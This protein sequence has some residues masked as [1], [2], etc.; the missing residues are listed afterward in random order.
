MKK[1]DLSFED[2]DDEKARELLPEEYEPLPYVSISS[3]IP[4]KLIKVRGFTTEADAIRRLK[5]INSVYPSNKYQIVPY[6]IEP[7]IHEFAIVIP[8]SAKAYLNKDEVIAD[9]DPPL[10]SRVSYSPVLY[11][12]LGSKKYENSFF[13]TG[14]LLISTFKRCQSKEVKDRQ[15]KYENQNR[16]IIVDGKYSI[17][18]VIGF[19]SPSLLLCTSL[20]QENTQTCGDT[21][22]FKINNADQFFDML[23]RALIS[24]GLSVCEVVKGPCVYNNKKI[25]LNASGTGFIGAFLKDSEQGCLNFLPSFQFI[26][27]QAENHILMNKPTCFASES[28]YRFVW[29]LTQPPR[30]ETVSE[31]VAV[32]GDGS[33]IVKVPELIPFCERL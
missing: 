21:Y 11:R 23:T 6:S 7:V 25:V 3:P 32:N 8:E 28:E 29:K 31:D 19:E 12:F 22:G 1:S 26:R 15:D 30:K 10:I 24:K 33:I 14:E 9:Y 2:F 5:E 18:A 16:F 20:S 13:E 27:E 17:D 4:E